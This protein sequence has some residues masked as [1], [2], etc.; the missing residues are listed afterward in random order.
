ME[1]RNQP[2]G[3]LGRRPQGIFRNEFRPRKRAAQYIREYEILLLD[4]LKGIPQDE[5]GQY[6]AKFKEWV[7]TLFAKHS[8]IM[9]AAI[10]G[11]A[12]F[13]TERNRKANNLRFSRRGISKLEE[14]TQKGNRPPHRSGQTAGAENRRSVGA[15]KGRY[16][17]FCRLE[18]VLDKLIQPFRNDCPKG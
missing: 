2:I 15:H 11:P 1:I 7:A 9:S 17:P 13:P 18:F 8:R 4:D 3:T 10:T 6:I 5:Q 16:R 12:R 14:R